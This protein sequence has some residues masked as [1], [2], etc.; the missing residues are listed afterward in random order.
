MD[1]DLCTHSSSLIHV[2]DSADLFFLLFPTNKTIGLTSLAKLMLECFAQHVYIPLPHCTAQHFC[3]CYGFHDFAMHVSCNVPIN[4]MPYL[5]YLG[6]D[7][8]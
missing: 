1:D 5:Q 4:G 8:E 3:Q 6:L 7:G 2:T